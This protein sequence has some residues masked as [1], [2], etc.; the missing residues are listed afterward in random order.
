MKKIIIILIILLFTIN[1]IN[2]GCFSSENKIILKKNSLPNCIKIETEN[3][4]IWWKYYIS[5]QCEKELLY[6]NKII[7]KWNILED[8]IPNENIKS[9]IIYDSKSYKFELY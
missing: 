6:K 1:N 7:Q 4:C 8:F 2:A 5:N 3:S 9:T